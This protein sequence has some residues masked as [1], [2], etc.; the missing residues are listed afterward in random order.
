[1]LRIFCA[2]SARET[3]HAVFA[4]KQNKHTVFARQRN[5]TY[6]VCGLGFRQSGEEH[7][8]H[9]PATQ[10]W[11]WLCNNNHNHTYTDN[12]INNSNGNSGGVAIIITVA[13]LHMCAHNVAIITYVCRLWMIYCKTLLN[14]AVEH[15]WYSV[16]CKGYIYLG[17]IPVSPNIHIYIYIYTCIYT[18]MCIYIYI[19]LF[20]YS[21]VYIYI[22]IHM[23]RCLFSHICIR[24]SLNTAKRTHTSS[25]IGGP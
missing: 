18:H 14:T 19:Y 23:C 15:A 11:F 21:C 17:Y 2:Y 7:L 16:F 8:G 25:Q 9:T 4:R 12:T 5:W 3:K 24:N 20:I 6:V 13:G 22:Y 1:M 10:W